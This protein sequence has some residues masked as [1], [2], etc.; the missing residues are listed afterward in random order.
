[1]EGRKKTILKT[2]E[3]RSVV[4]QSPSFR[5][6][7]VRAHA[8]TC[9]TLDGSA[10]SIVA[11]GL[12]PGDGLDQLDRPVDVAIDSDG[13]LYVAELGN[14]RVTRWKDKTG[15]VVAGGTGW[16]DALENL[17]SPTAICLQETP[18]GVCVLVAESGNNRVSRWTP[19]QARC[20]ILVGGVGS[21]PELET[22]VGLCRDE[23]DGSIYVA[24][25]RLAFLAVQ[26]KLTKNQF[27]F[28]PE[29]EEAGSNRVTRWTPG[30]LPGGA[31]AICIFTARGPGVQ[32]PLPL[33][34]SLLEARAVD[35]TSIN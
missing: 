30:A 10:T 23:T 7:D 11:G 34:R 4:A 29:S 3:N 18:D 19:G 15:E 6:A 27:S 22:P 25:A 20:E 32:E 31:R 1:M 8:V 28:S 5:I 17:A 12:G 24:A 16:G 13:C 26:D 35:A 9:W 21:L 2:R 33:E 14:D